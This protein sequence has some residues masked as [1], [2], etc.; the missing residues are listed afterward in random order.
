MI[1]LAQPARPTL[2]RLVLSVPPTG[3]AGGPGR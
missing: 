2:L 1:A 3:A